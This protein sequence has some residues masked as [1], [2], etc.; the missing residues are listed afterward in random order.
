MAQEILQNLITPN[1]HT[2]NK[3][4]S[5]KDRYFIDIYQ[6]DYK[7][8]KSQVETLL[9]D[10]ELRFNLSK[11]TTTDPKNIKK[12]VLDNFKPYFLNT[13]LTCKSSD[14]VSIVD[15]QQRLTTLLIMLIALR[16]LVNEV[17]SNVQYLVKTLSVNTLDK[18]IFEADDFDKPQYYKVYNT[19][20]QGAFDYIL[21]NISEYEPKDETQKKILENYEIILTYFNSFFK[22]EDFLPIDV[23][24]LTYYI[25]YILEKLNIVEIHIE[26]QENVATIFEVVNDRGLG[27]KPYEI[28]KGKFL[29]NLTEV[30]KEK[31]N[32]I[33]I[34]LQNQY[35]NSNIKNSTENE[36][37]L[38]AF[39]K[40]YLRAK[41]ADTENDYK[42]F[43]D[44]YHYEIYQNPKILTFFNRFEDNEILFNW[45]SNEF[46][47]F[48]ELHL[49]IRTTYDYDYLIFNKLLDQNQ[50]YLLIISAIELND[51]QE[52]EKINLVAKKFDQMHSTI[53]LLDLYESNDFQDLIYKLMPKIRNKGLDEITKAFDNVLIEYLE[54]EEII[55]KDAYTTIGDLYKFD[56]FQNVRNRWI[57]FSKY[58]L[59]R[60]DNY[61]AKVLDK[62]SYCNDTLMNIEERFNKNNLKRYGMHLEHIYANND[63]N[64][65]LFTD[66][67]GMFDESKFNTVRNKLGMVLL[68]KDKQNISSNNDYY[69][70]KVD[71]YK[72]SNIIWDELLVGHI[73]SID[74]RN[75]PE[76]INFSEIEPNSDGVFPIEMVETRQ[77][78]TFE[79]LKL[80][81]GF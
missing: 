5:E 9:R 48:A 13:Y 63:K 14:Y 68:L 12:A 29:G 37:D 75:L 8:Q 35:Y 17:H 47:Y 16:K 31:A 79:I 6:R 52:E 50:Q 26:Q 55:S 30:Q 51:K 7:W 33:W 2:I 77:K 43:E 11:R 61:L 42:K 19:N 40:I 34:K 4:F 70:L 69:I 21:G 45:V 3:V 78:E 67:S 44:K 20:R 38:D 46:K 64:K 25:Y 49:K 81:W 54:V 66:S 32:E 62:P 15:G 10:I 65:L 76:E 36:I 71:D 57:N 27:L 58:T 72:T 73:D 23:N 53:R 18:L 1:A 24:K 80:I 41:F 74:R 28:L 59:M 39:F 60:I 22:S 56:L